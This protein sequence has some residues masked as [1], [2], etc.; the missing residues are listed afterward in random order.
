MLLIVIVQRENCLF[1][2]QTSVYLGI[3]R[4]GCLVAFMGLFLLHMWWS[5]PF[6][7]PI[8]NRSDLVSRFGYVAIAV[9]GLLVALDV[10]GKDDLGG[11]VLIL[12]NVVV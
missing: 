1:R 11:P 9:L 3:V 6:I 8:S 7:D 5:Q 10:K 12:V 2:S 4:Q